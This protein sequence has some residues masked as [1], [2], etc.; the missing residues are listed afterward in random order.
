MHRYKNRNSYIKLC[1]ALSVFVYFCAG[2]NKTTNLDRSFPIFLYSNKNESSGG[3]RGVAR[4]VP[5]PPPAP[6]FFRFHAVFGK[7]LAKSYVG[8]PGELAPPGELY[9]LCNVLH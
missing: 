1:C 4:G 7:N 2:P 8:T 6:K 5:P 3:S 9:S